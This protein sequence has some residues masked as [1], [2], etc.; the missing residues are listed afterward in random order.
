[1]KKPQK[2]HK[3]ELI[4]LL[5]T[6][7]CLAFTAG[8]F[9]GKSTAGGIVTVERLAV[10]PAETPFDTAPS[11]LTFPDATPSAS[12]PDASATPSEMT[13]TAGLYTK[14]N[15]NTATIT[16]LDSL[17]GIGTVIAGNIITY[18]ESHGKFTT[19]DELMDVDG[20]GQAKLAALKDRITVG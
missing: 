20:I 14:V 15:I 10:V 5:L 19:I 11:A 17:P 18:R 6:V 2:L 7:L 8:Y 9:T 4:I 16:E 13:E 12:V 1:M 3:A